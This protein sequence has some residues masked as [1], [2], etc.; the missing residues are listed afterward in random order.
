MVNFE[1]KLHGLQTEL[2]SADLIHSLQKY[3][4]VDEAEP[5]EPLIGISNATV[6]FGDTEVTSERMTEEDLLKGIEGLALVP[7]EEPEEDLREED[8]NPLLRI[9]LPSRNI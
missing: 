4:E 7:R 9:E 5:G 8:A 1:R 3:V 2:R 6:D